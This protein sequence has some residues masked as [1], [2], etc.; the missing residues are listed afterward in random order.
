MPSR[1]QALKA[2]ADQARTSHAYH[3][4][5]ASIRFTE[6]V[7]ARMESCGITRT[8][9]AEKIGTSPAYVTKIL[10]GDTN[11]T[12]ESM[13]K[14]AQALDCEMDFELRPLTR[15]VTYHS[16]TPPPVS[17]LNDKAQ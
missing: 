14:I 10:R 17:L 11:F 4:E 7:I 6:A 2:K 5:G 13:V 8:D 15:K 16:N 12:L 9:L 1:L 3:A